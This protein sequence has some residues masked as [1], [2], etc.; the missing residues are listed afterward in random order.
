MTSSLSKDLASFKKR[1]QD[2]P[3]IQHK[4]IKIKQEDQEEPTTSKDQSSTNL[5]PTAPFLYSNTTTSLSSQLFEI[6]KV[7]K[8]KNKPLTNSEIIRWAAI[9]V[10]ATPLLLARMK[11]NQRLTYDPLA[12]TFQFKP[13][14]HIQTP[15]AL[16]A[17]LQQNRGVCGMD[18]KE[19]KESYEKITDVI[20]EL[21]GNGSALVLRNGK[22]NAAKIVYYNDS[23]FN[24]PI[25]DGMFCL[26]CLVFCRSSVFASCEYLFY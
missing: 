15:S 1:L 24:V 17:L 18:V 12:L 21:E 26:S 5:K 23:V 14:Y 8:E 2:Q 4:K 25:S 10:E 3:T 9:D 19:L 16:L 13:R 22:D 6:I 7:L 20:D 11:S